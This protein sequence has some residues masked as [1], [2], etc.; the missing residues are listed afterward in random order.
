MYSLKLFGGAALEGPAGPVS[1][2]PVHRR[3]L[4]VLALLATAT[5]PVTRERLTGYLWPQHPSDAAR[6][7]LSESFY[8]LRKAVGEDL[9]T[10]DGDEIAINPAVLRSDVQEF[11]DAVVSGDLERAVALYRGPFMDGFDVSDAPGFERW[12]LSTRV[13]LAQT[14]EDAV[15]A[16]ASL[17]KR[18][19][20][21]APDA[22]WE[23]GG[24]VLSVVV[25]PGTAPPEEI[26]DVLARLSLLYRKL[27]GSGITFSMRETH[28][29]E[30][31]PW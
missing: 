18:R 8:I 24:D 5:S 6:H 3:R 29:L 4:A 14:Y 1:G 2:R 11:R 13:R 26:A 25:D 23:P 28:V 19:P 15:Q 20:A 31:E 30:P 9:F 7:L 17:E 27:G 21:P 12:M 10:S 22:S 16:L